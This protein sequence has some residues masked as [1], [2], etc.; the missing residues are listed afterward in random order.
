[1]GE[2]Y[3]KSGIDIIGDIPWG[4]HLCLFYKNKEDL[5]DIL[6]QFFKVG[7]ENNELCMWI[8]SEP[9]GVE[10][11]KQSLNKEVKNLDDYFIKHQIEIL[12]YSQWYT[13]S[14]M[15]E[16]D[17]VMES[18]IKKEEQALKEGFDGLRVSGDTLWLEK[19]DWRN[20]SGYEETVNN[21]I[22]QHKMHLTNILLMQF[23]GNSKL[24][25]LIFVEVSNF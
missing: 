18:W 2:K 25:W 12:D 10:S 19:K 14:G 1:M 3:R 6:K 11:A 9:S 7:L 4:S 21:I 23:L 13:K 16:V 17:K 15:F 8:T 5:I 24:N 20:L 22:H